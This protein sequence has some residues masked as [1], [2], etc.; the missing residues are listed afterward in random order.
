[1]RVILLFCLMLLPLLQISQGG[2]FCATA[3][4]VEELEKNIL[5]PPVGESRTRDVLKNT[6]KLIPGSLREQMQA[7][8]V[9]EG[10]QFH[11][12][13]DYDIIV[14]FPGD[15]DG[16]LYDAITDVI[17]ALQREGASIRAT[18]YDRSKIIVIQ[19]DM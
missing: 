12:R 6:F 15:F 3:G 17:T 18:I 13:S 4:E 16:T 5:S 11:W 2:A 9:N 8:A 14:D 1:M 7:W 10:Y 19:G